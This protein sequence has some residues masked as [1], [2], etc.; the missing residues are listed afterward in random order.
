V[1]G[2]LAPD[3]VLHLAGTPHLD[4]QGYLQTFGPYKVAF[5][6]LRHTIEDQVAA[7]DRVVSRV[8]IRATRFG[9]FQVL[10][11]TGNSAAVALVTITRI[12]GGKVAED[13]SIM[14][15]MSIMQAVGAMAAPA[16][17]PA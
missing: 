11:P 13:W 4:T 6:D 14:D 3:F 7:G 1:L 17:S 2:L 9:E 5:P 15:S 10:R 8:T 16:G 12:A